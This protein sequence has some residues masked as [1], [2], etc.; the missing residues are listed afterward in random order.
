MR[1]GDVANVV[2]LRHGLAEVLEIIIHGEESSSHVIGRMV[3]ELKMPTGAV[4]GA[5]LRGND[6]LIGDSRTVI[7]AGDH[8]VVY[9]SEKKYISDVEKLF[10]PTAFFI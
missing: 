4:I 8:V 3:N 1:K 9:L 7:Q 6:V 5:I 2:S 10:Q